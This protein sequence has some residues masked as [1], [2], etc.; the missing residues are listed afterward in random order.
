[1][2]T[3]YQWFLEELEK[4]GYGEEDIVLI[5]D[6]F[7]KASI[8]LEKFKKLSSEGFEVFEKEEDK[9]HPVDVAISNLIIYLSDNSMITYLRT[10]PCHDYEINDN[11]LKLIK[12]AQALGK[13]KELEVKPFLVKRN[14]MAFGEKP[15]EILFDSGCENQIDVELTD[16]ATSSYYAVFSKHSV[17]PCIVLS[18]GLKK[19]VFLT[20]IMSAGEVDYYMEVLNQ[21]PIRFD[22]LFLTKLCVMLNI[23]I[24]EL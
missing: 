8:S 20:S 21:F 1:M 10:E 17:E 7:Q 13:L 4:L 23:D 6:V 11:S 12:S 2:K 22:D 5:T 14:R 24:R 3:F 9:T 19:I 18:T 16:A 15:L